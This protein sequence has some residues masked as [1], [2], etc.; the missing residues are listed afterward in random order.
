MVSARKIKD[1]E[2][3]ID[4]LKRQLEALRKESRD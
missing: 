1:L 2:N 4:E 3:Q